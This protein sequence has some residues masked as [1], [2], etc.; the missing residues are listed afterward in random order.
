MMNIE[1]KDALDMKRDVLVLGLFD[2]DNELYRKYNRE[3]ADDLSDAIQRKAF[4]R[5][6][7]KVYVSKVNSS[8]YKRILIVSLGKKTEF[9]IDRI[10]KSMSRIVSYL[11]AAKFSTF[12]T[13]IAI[14]ANEL[15]IDKKKMGMAIAEG[16]TLSEYTFDKYKSKKNSE[17]KFSG[18]VQF[19]KNI[20]FTEGLIQGRVIAE[21]TNYAKDMVNEPA[22]VVTPTYLESAAKELAKSNAKIT[23]KILN[24]KDMEKEGLNAIL[25]V[26]A[27]S[28]QDPK[29]IIIEYNNGSK[30][31]TAI[32][33]KGI[34]FDSGGYDIKPA[35]QFADM[36]IDMSGAAAVLGIIKT[37]AQLNLKVNLVG[38]IPSCENL[39]DGSAMKP[40]D[41]IR[42]YNGKT[43]EVMNTD[44]E[45]RLILADA[46]SYTEKN[47]KPS[48]IIDL[49]TL[50]GACIIALGNYASGLV[51]NNE[52]LGNALF[53]AGM[54]SNDR[55]WIL[56]FFE[57]YQD[58]MDGDITDLK[59]IS[60]KGKGREA[61]AITGGVFISKF[62]DKAAWAHIDIAGPAY[63][64]ETKDYNQKYAS[65]TGIRLL[66]YY[67][68]N[69][70]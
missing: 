37:A 30:E 43:I 14:L 26:S 9:T 13:N 20:D 47:Y 65:G 7:G 8:G 19:P 12:T 69:K 40:G 5:D 23:V 54:E 63:L 68:M 25:A 48:I 70:K 38:V 61:G 33:G 28:D 36:K 21:S 67:L 64:S 49:A 10:R 39:I 45:G 51:T 41:I 52:Q 1:V 62:V 35:G 24:K 31:K 29:L 17:L 18:S 34:T 6:F 53:S 60:V 66:S 32:V 3:L 55:I 58:N 46:V 22:V 44:A 56:P 16:L 11:K 15:Q 2:D 4:E 27:G 42:A 50:T 59:N 57:D